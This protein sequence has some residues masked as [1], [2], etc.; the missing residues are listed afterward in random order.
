VKIYTALLR[1][2][3]EPVLMREG[4]A[5]GALFFGPVWLAVHRAWIA[6]AITLA[7]YVLIAVFAP[8]P[9]A[10]ILT[11]GLALILGFTG[12]D[13]RRWALE[14]R[15]YLLAHVLAARDRDDAF[16]RLLVLRPDL[17]ARYR[18]EPA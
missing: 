17:T 2:D 15:G 8:T 10:M 1:Q 18:P 16:M 3:A 6:A 11:A 4:F 9:A 5:W 13:L 14:W 12:Q 7:A